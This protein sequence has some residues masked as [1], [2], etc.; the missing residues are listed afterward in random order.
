MKTILITQSVF[1]VD[2]AFQKRP[3]PVPTRPPRQIAFFLFCSEA[4]TATSDNAKCMHF[5][6]RT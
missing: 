2:A 1:L 4:P 6:P 3:N 5:L